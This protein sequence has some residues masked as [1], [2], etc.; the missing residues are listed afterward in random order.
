MLH[1]KIIISINN[2][3]IRKRCIGA[4]FFLELL[5]LHKEINEESLYHAY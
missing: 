1:L 5:L 4:E 3:N 2:M